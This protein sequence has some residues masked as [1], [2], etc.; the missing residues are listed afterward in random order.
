MPNMKT[1]FFVF[2]GFVTLV[3]RIYAIRG[4]NQQILHHNTR[5]YAMVSNFPKTNFMISLFVY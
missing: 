3:N 1:L 4:N 2:Q 5:G